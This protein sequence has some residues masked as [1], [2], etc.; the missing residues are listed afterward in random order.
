MLGAIA[1][2]IGPQPT[3]QLAGALCLLA[4]MAVHLAMPV[5]RRLA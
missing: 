3:L 2:A 5:L 1:E 4:A